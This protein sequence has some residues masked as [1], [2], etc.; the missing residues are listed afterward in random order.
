[1]N[2]AIETST[3]GHPDDKDQRI[4]FFNGENAIISRENLMD[5]ICPVHKQI[6]NYFTVKGW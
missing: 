6:E 1:M 2:F 5:P 3:K 4:F